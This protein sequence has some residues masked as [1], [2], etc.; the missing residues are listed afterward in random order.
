MDDIDH[1]DGSPMARAL[2]IAPGANLAVVNEPDGWLDV[3]APLPRATRLFERASQP[4]DVIVYFSDER[5]NVARRV[6]ALAGFLAAS[7][8]LWSAVPTA[9]TD[10]GPA[11]VLEVARLSGLSAR[12]SLEIAEGWTATRLVG[13]GV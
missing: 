4:L 3:L 10:V 5:A 9:G 1:P 13:A 11:D 12:G 7:G 2:G 6:P 8:S